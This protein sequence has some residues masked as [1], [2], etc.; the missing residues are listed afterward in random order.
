M[1]PSLP[2]CGSPVPRLHLE[3]RERV[4]CVWWA[5]NVFAGLGLCVLCCVVCV[6]VFVCVRT[7][8]LCA[9]ACTGERS[10][11]PPLVPLFLIVVRVVVVVPGVLICPPPPTHTQL[12]GT[13]SC[14]T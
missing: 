7:T 14:K 1:V 5:L 11:P 9:H 8:L 12:E 13:P 3:L 2:R 6:C 4:S 10:V